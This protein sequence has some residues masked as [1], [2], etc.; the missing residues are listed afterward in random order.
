MLKSLCKVLFN[1]IFVNILFFITVSW[2][3]NWQLPWKWSLEES[4]DSVELAKHLIFCLICED[5]VFYIM[6][7][8]LHCQPFYQLVH[9][10]HHQFTT[11]VSIAAECSHP[12]EHFF[13]GNLSWIAGPLLLGS[14]AHIWTINLWGILRHLQSHE[15][16]S[17]YEFPWS[18]WRIIPFQSDASYH[19]YHHATNI[20]NYAST[21]NIWD[22]LFNTNVDYF[23]S[24]NQIE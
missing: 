2:L 12:F 6:H 7:R 16:H 19:D 13:C 14:K 1:A 5:L 8:L 9:K 3:Y 10:Q 22:T 4:P 24:Q 17:G 21:M 20:G 23:V 18:M 11:T 15:G